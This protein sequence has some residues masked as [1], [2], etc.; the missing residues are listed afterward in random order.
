MPSESAGAGTGVGCDVAL[1]A[2]LDVDFDVGFDLDALPVFFLRPL[3]PT[4]LR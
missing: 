4:P 3:M 2:A 1:D